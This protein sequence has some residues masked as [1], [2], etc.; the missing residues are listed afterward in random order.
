MVHRDINMDNILVFKS[1]FS[2]I[3]LCDFGATRK[4]GALLKKKTVWLPYAPPE[5]VDAVQNEGYHVDT[6]QVRDRF[7]LETK[8]FRMLYC[9]RV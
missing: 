6:T 3:K 2:K 9:R 1:D 8:M 5:I 7:M 4:A